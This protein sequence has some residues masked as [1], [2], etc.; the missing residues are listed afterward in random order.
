MM[1]KVGQKVRFVDADAHERSPKFYPPVG[2]IGIV[3]EIDLDDMALVDWGIDSGVWGRIDD[4][5]Y[6]WATNRMLE[7]VDAE[8]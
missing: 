3:M 5:Y 1:F 2:T 6:W 4:G 8:S 7:A